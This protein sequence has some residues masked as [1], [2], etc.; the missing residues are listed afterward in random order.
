MLKD[1]GTLC[2]VDFDPGAPCKRAYHHSP[3]LWSYKMDYAA[4]FLANPA[5]RLAEKV[6]ASHDSLAFSADPQE[7][8]GIW[9]CRKD[10]A[11][12]NAT[13]GSP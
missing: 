1:G 6:S 7:R 5:Y 8:I 2:I 3:G 4:L 13:C 12:A 9:S 11:N 10:V